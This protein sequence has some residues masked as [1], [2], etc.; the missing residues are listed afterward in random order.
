MFPGSVYRLVP[1]IIMFRY[2]SVMA[3]LFTVLQASH[4][5]H[6]IMHHWLCLYPEEEPLR[7]NHFALTAEIESQF[8]S[9]SVRSEVSGAEGPGAQ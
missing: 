8:Q 1:C 5:L 2:P 6:A 4:A 7:G 3:E 9:L